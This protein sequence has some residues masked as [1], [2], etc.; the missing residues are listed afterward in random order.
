MASAWVS[1]QTPNFAGTYW[2]GMLDQITHLVLP[3][4]AIML[5]SFAGYSRYSRATMLET[6]SQDYV[7][8]ARS[9]GLTER[10]VVLRHALRNAL[11]PLTTLAAYDFGNIMGGAVIT[12]T[13]FARS[14]M[15]SMFVTGL[16]H[17]DPNP[18]MGFYIV[19]A[20]SIMVFT[21]LADIAYAHLDPRIR[22]G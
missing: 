6:M 12:E 3:V 10:R 8:T 4:M 1:P 2:Q 18:V 14:G 11:I 20:A 16:L 21:M 17:T 22:L 9:K 15:G 5:V 7:R 19:T 13:V